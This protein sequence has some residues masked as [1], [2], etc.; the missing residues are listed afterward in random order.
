MS[1]RPNDPILPVEPDADADGSEDAGGEGGFDF[2]E[3]DKQRRDM[4]KKTLGVTLRLSQVQ[5]RGADGQ[6]VTESYRDYAR[7]TLIA[8]YPTLEMFLTAWFQAEHKQSIVAELYHLGI[9]MD[10]LQE[11]LGF[12]LDAFDLICHLAF[13][14]KALTRR[15][16]A[17]KVRS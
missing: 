9:F 1:Q 14:R 13:G 12:D 7:H 8:R 11:E 17:N 4:L 10:K 6:L 16:R 2:Y 3:Y 15:E 5:Y